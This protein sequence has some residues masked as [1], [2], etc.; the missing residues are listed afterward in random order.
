MSTILNISVSGYIQTDSYFGLINDVQHDSQVI[1]SSFKYQL[2][3]TASANDCV[4]FALSKGQWKITGLVFAGFIGYP[5]APRNPIVGQCDC[6]DGSIN[7]REYAT[8]KS[9]VE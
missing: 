9:E 7:C 8:N 6:L 1:I 4:F 2:H 3:I 5:L